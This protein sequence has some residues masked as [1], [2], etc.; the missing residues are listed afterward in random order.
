MSTPKEMKCIRQYHLLKGKSGGVLPSLHF[1][2]LG[3]IS[4]AMPL[5]NG[6][7]G[8]LQNRFADVR[9]YFLLHLLH[10][11]LYHSCVVQRYYRQHLDTTD[12]C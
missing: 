5:L 7:I 12:N 1:I 9:F 6:E 2:F 8:K 4:Q 3:T 11:S 10:Q